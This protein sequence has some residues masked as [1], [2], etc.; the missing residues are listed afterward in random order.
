MDD[1]VFCQFVRGEAPVHTVLET[2]DALAFLDNEPAAPYHTLVV[3]KRHSTNLFDVPE[4]D[5]HAVMAAVKRVVDLYRDRL[6]VEAVE[7]ACNSGAE[8]QQAVFHLHV[9]VV[10]RHPGD[11]LDTEWERHPEM[12]ERFDTMLA[13]LQDP[14][15]GGVS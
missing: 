15:A 9:H 4:A 10:P 11:G 7:V 8:A 12:Q 6:G 2:D 5:L 1:C 14:E 13:R 3:P